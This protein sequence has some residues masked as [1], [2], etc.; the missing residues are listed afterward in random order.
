VVQRGGSERHVKLERRQWPARAAT[1]A[2]V[3]TLPE[4]R[5]LFGSDVLR[6]GV[7]LRTG[8]VALLFTD[9]TQSTALYR[10]M[11][12]AK[13]F[14]LVHDH[15]DLVQKIVAEHHG[16]VVK[17][18]GDAVMAAFVDDTDAVRAAL[19]LHASLR[20]FRGDHA[21]FEQG[22]FKIGIYA[23]PCYCVTAN[24][25]LDYFGQTVNIAARLQAQ[26]GAGEL[27]LAEEACEAMTRA[28]IIDDE[29]LVRF[30]ADLKGVGRLKLARLPVDSEVH[31]EGADAGS[32]S[33]QTG[34]DV[35]EAPLDS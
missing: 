13:A 11:G 10:S 30:A 35:T 14:Q 25:I 26:A 17:T 1:A 29:R 19:G 33:R 34:A 27:V 15:F 3:S 24:G 5:R 31:S 28:G 8:R 32:R 9:L 12:D 4:F 2:V 6:Q 22:Y 20:A 23:G 18:M 7:S 21:G 16:T